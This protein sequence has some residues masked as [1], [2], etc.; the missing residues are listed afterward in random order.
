MLT[1]FIRTQLILFTIAAIVGVSVMVFA[2]MQVPMLLGIGRMT[3]KIELPEAGG[4]YRFSNVTYRGTQVGKV[5]SVTLTDDGVEATMSLVGS[6][7]I[8]ADLRAEVRSMSAVGEQYIELLPRTDSPP[9]LENG[10]VIPRSDTSVPQAVGPML[11]QLSTL[12]NTIPKDS[13]SRLL[14]ESFEAFNDTGYEFGSLLDSSATVTRDANAVADQTRLLAEDAEPFLD[15]QAQTTDSIRVWAASLAGITDQ[16]DKN[17]PQIRTV[18]REGPGFAQE[19]AQLLEQARPT[20][21]VLLANMTTFGKIGVS[22]NP[23]IE[24]LLVLVPP[25]VA[26][27]Q[28]YAPTTSPNGLPN[29]EFSL[30]LGDPAA[31]TVGFLPPSAWRSPADTTVVDTPE[32][33]YCKLPQDSPV[34]VRGARNYPCMEHPGK[35]APTVELCNDPEGYKPVATRQHALGPYPFDPNLVSQGVPIDARARLD[36]NTFGPVEGTPLPPGV[37]APP[38]RIPQAPSPPPNFAGTGP[39]ALLPGQPLYTE[40]PVSPPG[41]AQVTEPD[42]VPAPPAQ[43]PSATEVPVPPG[44]NPD[45]LHLPPGAVPV[46]GP[47]SGTVISPSSSSSARDGGPTVAFARYN[48][49][50]G[51]YMASDGRLY[52]QSD[53]S[54]TP[55]SWQELMPT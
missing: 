8:P 42:I 34:A 32:G 16:L 28:T 1:R 12:V 4:L 51:E 29:G 3:V 30:G 33:L 49:R 37:T 36:D 48:P 47:G 20:L 27:I 41:P 7:K 25:F 21:P 52:R 11:E 24:Q 17:D 45:D 50:T 54:S 10:S 55:K 46:P 2:Y 53:L 23:S 26:Q 40:P 44:V 31:C 6:A 39:G 5:Q 38:P 9:Y 43:L 18:L 22:Y 13:L 35:R 15:A 19:T 14:D